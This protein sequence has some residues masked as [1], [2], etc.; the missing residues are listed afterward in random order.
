MRIE[1]SWFSL[2]TRSNM[3]S[4]NIS[5]MMKDHQ[6]MRCGDSA[7]PVWT[8]ERK[9]TSEN[10]ERNMKKER[11]LHRYLPLRFYVW[12][13]FGLDSPN[14]AGWEDMLINMWSTICLLVNNNFP[15]IFHSTDWHDSF[16]YSTDEGK[17]YWIGFLNTI[18]LRI[19]IG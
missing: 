11:Y 17:C 8:S 14:K 10:I 5:V 7:P 19:D 6:H 3:Q 18:L 16:K 4:T 12:H 2:E 15:R 9:W 13:K 1:V